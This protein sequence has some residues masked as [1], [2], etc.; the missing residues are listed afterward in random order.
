MADKDQKL[1]DMAQP[2]RHRTSTRRQGVKGITVVERRPL[3]MIR[4]EISTER[5]L[6]QRFPLHVE[7]D[8]VVVIY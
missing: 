2:A 7:S 8:F 5:I 1:A 4:P 6:E 3:F